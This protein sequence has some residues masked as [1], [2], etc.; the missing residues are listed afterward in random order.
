MG[1]SLEDTFNEADDYMYQEK[2]Y[3]SAEAHE[4]I[5]ATI[6]YKLDD[7]DYITAGH[8][9]RLKELSIKLGTKFELSSRQLKDLV[10][11]AQAHDVGKISIPKDVLFKEQPLTEAEW[12]II[13]AHAEKGYRIARSIPTLATVADLILRHHE[14]WDGTGYPPSV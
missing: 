13:R 3:R 4:K 6:L 12:K 10:I 5:A 7:L 8:A 9:E 14:R 2:L 1:G 11:L